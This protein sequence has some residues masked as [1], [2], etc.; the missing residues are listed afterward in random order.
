MNACSTRRRTVSRKPALVL[1]SL[2]RHI[3]AV[4]FTMHRQ[5]HLEMNAES[6]SSQGASLARLENSKGTEPE[7]PARQPHRQIRKERRR[8]P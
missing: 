2:R 4:P 5:R 3:G 6:A 1:E 7:A 8:I